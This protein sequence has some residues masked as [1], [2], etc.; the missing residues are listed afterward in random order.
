MEPITIRLFHG[1]QFVT[2]NNKT[3]Y[4]RGD[5]PKAG[6]ALHTNVDEVC[7]F[8]FCDWIK[9]DLGYDEVGQIWF[10]RR[11]CSLNGNGRKEIKSDAEIPDFLSAPEKDGSYNL[12]VVHV[13]KGFDPRS[14][15]PAYVRWYTESES[16][17][18]EGSGGGSNSVSV[19]S[20][21][22]APSVVQVSST[23]SPNSQ[24]PQSSQH[25][26][27]V[28]KLPP[29][30]NLTR[31]NLPP[32]SNLNPSLI[33]PSI[34]QKPFSLLDQA[35]RQKLPTVSLFKRTLDQKR[36]Q[37]G[38]TGGGDE[39]R[40]VVAGVEQERAV[41]E[42]KRA[43]ASEGKRG[44][45]EGKR[46]A[47]S[48]GKRGGFKGKRAAASE[49]RTGEGAAGEDSVAEGGCEDSEDSD[50]LLSDNDFEDESDDDL[51]H[52]F[53][54]HEISEDVCRSLGALTG[55][56]GGVVEKNDSD[57]E[58]E[59]GEQEI[60][61]DVELNDSDGEVVSVIGS[62]DEGPNY[63]VF[64][65]AVDFKGSVELWKGLKFPSNIILRN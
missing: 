23:V 13:E 12:Y 6:M 28:N 25:S 26:Q 5:N 62:D 59:V 4:E 44:V 14:R 60:G 7:Y 45:F 49:G 20:A 17:T 41:F 57:E 31:N 32:P 35:V 52:E 50:V 54:D 2:N 22:G 51:F 40:L 39:E 11:G 34:P 58:G 36:A 30:T 46:A 43:A 1:G 53:V 48:E 27:H 16:D 64:N 3:T 56:V 38:V 19:D 10:R 9:R 37:L 33:L 61:D 47:A 24:T 18:T 8:E 29:L 55:A 63:P 21:R 15:F 42:G 65:P